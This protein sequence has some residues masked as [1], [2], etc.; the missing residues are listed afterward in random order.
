MLGP[1]ESV[2]ASVVA[3]FA[4]HASASWLVLERWKPP[5]SNIRVL[6]FAVGSV[7]GMAALQSAFLN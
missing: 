3:G 5:N 7:G 4:C 1:F 2:L 6:T